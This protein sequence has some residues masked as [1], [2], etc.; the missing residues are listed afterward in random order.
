[1]SLFEYLPSLRAAIPASTAAEPVRSFDPVSARTI[2]RSWRRAL[3]GSEVTYTAPPL[4]S[5]MADALATTGMSLEVRSPLDLG[6]ALAASFDQRRMIGHPR[7][8]ASTGLL[9]LMKRARIERY[10]V[11]NDDQLSMLAACSPA[12]CR[13]VLRLAAFAGDS[14]AD[15]TIDDAIAQVVAD[16]RMEFLGLRA[17]V[18]D[19]ADS[20]DRAVRSASA[21]FEQA[22]RDHHV[23]GAELQLSGTTTGL[24]TRE[25]ASTTADS[26]DT[27]CARNRFPRPRVVHILEDLFG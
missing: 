27:W 17:T 10:V 13:V 5:H 26:L 14:F 23:I 24:T 15:D 25:L 9:E 11:D 7:P 22:R 19:S 12:P 3:A 1:M 2:C 20:V 4:T 16:P 6:I 21:H 18:G 8:L